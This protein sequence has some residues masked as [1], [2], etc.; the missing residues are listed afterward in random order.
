MLALFVCLMLYKKPNRTHN[1]T[2]EQPHDEDMHPTD[3]TAPDSMDLLQH[4]ALERIAPQWATFLSLLGNELASQLTP[5]ELRQLLVRLGSRFA[6]TNPLGPCEDVPALQN[7]F[8]RVWGPMQWGYATVS[9]LGQHLAVTHRACPLPAALQW[10]A[11]LVG[12]Y[13]EGAYGVWLHAAGAPAEL[14][15]KQQAASGL[16]MHMVFELTAR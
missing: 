3:P 10:D 16:P 4:L 11:E 8:N 6:E 5:E 9:D 2:F 13:L 14:V 7:A 12:G 15:L 1:P